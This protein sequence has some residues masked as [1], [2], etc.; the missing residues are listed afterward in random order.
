MDRLFAMEAFVAIVDAGSITAAAQSLD[1][2]QPSLVRRLAA[3]ERDLGA[4]LLHRTTRRM[5]LTDEGR[6]YYE[7][8]RQI[9][10]AVN[11]A[12]HQLSVRQAVPRGRL[13]IASS[14]AFGR[15]FVAPVA[16]EFLAGNPE[17]QMELLLVDRVVDLVEEGID[18]AI[19][20]AR[21]PDSSMVAHPVGEVHRVVVASPA[22][23]KSVGKPK[24]PEQ[25]KGA[26]CVSFTGL[27]SPAHWAFPVGRKAG[28]VP[29]HSVFVSN[30]IDAAVAACLG[31]VG[32]GR[33]LDYQVLD[34]IQSGRLVRVLRPHEGEPIPV[35]VLYP[36][37]RHP[38]ANVRGFVA[39]AQPRLKAAL[40]AL[41]AG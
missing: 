40:R 17:L 14:V 39:F 19:R 30:Q 33:F 6:D 38:S 13:R 10:Q 35:S 4:R 22:F 5:S 28:Q 21:L 25:L 8:S 15:R 31:G 16:A 29:V 7:R 1:V 23:L 27:T 34:H 24:T 26:R 2:S 20:L 18:V 36:S 41:Q 9:L 11:D 3:L 37:A 32:F 12:R